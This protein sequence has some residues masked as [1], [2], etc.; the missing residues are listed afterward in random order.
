METP[1]EYE[2]LTWAITSLVLALIHTGFPKQI[3][4]ISTFLALCIM[5][6]VIAYILIALPHANF[7]KNAFIGNTTNSNQFII[8]MFHCI[9]VA[10]LLF[11]GIEMIPFTC[12]EVKEVS[13]LL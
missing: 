5:G 3:F 11:S 10:S 6:V 2:P 12:G 9:P 1:K 8:S 7:S 13:S 4:S